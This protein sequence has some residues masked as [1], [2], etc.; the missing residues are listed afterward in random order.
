MRYSLMTALTLLLSPLTLHAQALSCGDRVITAPETCDDGNTRNGDGCSSTCTLDQTIEMVPLVG[1][2]FLRGDLGYRDTIP[3]ALVTI[4]NFSLSRTEITLSMYAKCVDD[5]HCE[6]P[7]GGSFCNWGMAGRSTHPMNCVSW[8]EA[9]VFADWLNSKDTVNTI[10]LPSE[11]QWEYAARSQG[12]DQ[13]YPWG[14]DTASCDRSILKDGGYGCG[15]FSTAPVCS[16]SHTDQVNVPANGDGDSAQGICDLI[17]NTSEWTADWYDSSYNGKPNDGSPYIGLSRN[18]YRVVRGGGW[19]TAPSLANSTVRQRI[20]FRFRQAYTGFRIASRLSCGDGILDEYEEC[21]DGNRID[22][23]GCDASCLLECGN[24]VQQ[25]NE[26]CD[27]GNTDIGDGC[28]ESCIIEICGNG[29]VQINESCDDGALLNG[30]GC[31]NACQEEICGNGILQAAIGEACDDGNTDNNDGCDANCFQEVCGNGVAQ[32]HIGESCD[33]GDND[34]NNGCNNICQLQICG[35]GILQ[36]TEACDDG[37]NNSDLLAGACRT[38]CQLPGCG[39]GVQDTNEACDNGLNNNDVLADACRTNCQLPICGDGVQDSGEA[40]DLGNGN[41]DTAVDGCRTS[42]NFAFCGDGIQDTGEVCDDGINNS[43]VN[44]DACRTSCQ[45]HFCSDGVNDSDEQC[46]D[47]NL[48]PSDGC[49]E[50][51][52]VEECGNGLIQTYERRYLS[53]SGGSAQ[54]C[55][56][57]VDN[58]I[59]CWGESL[60]GVDQTKSKPGGQFSLIEIGTVHACAIGL[61]NEVECWGA[62]DLGQADPPNELMTDVSAGLMDQSCGVKLNGDLVCWGEMVYDFGVFPDPPVGSFSKVAIG[63]NFGV[64]LH[65]CAINNAG[66]IECWGDNDRGQLDA[67]AGTYSDLSAGGD[68]TC[69]LSTT[70]QIDCWGANDFGQTNA[71]AGQFVEVASHL[72]HSCARDINDNVTCWGGFNFGGELDVVAGTYISV[73]VGF[74]HSCA[75]DFNNQ[76]VCWGDTSLGQSTPTPGPYETCDDGN[77]ADGDGCDATCTPEVCGNGVQQ[78]SEECDDNNNVDG[79][80]CSA[81]CQ[82]ESCG[83]GVVQFGEDCDKV[84]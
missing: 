48:L 57:M 1:G 43:D 11:S 17:G 45:P 50:A 83:N 20:N 5:G 62:N 80:G 40:C 64:T 59:N 58:Y 68:F 26:Q 66:Q 54:T 84:V 32:T 81:T 79:D 78:G 23:D 63:G 13:T 7:A 31:D 75:V 61:S 69:A 22:N 74:S 12:Q 27:D 2:V 29:V 71:P 56:I 46:D 19:T 41:S 34:D 72:G 55:G 9:T 18:R 8:T 30:D 10:S 24:G 37:V 42:C 16:R 35:D 3:L 33:D 25:G 65:G 52:L 67:P 73:D 76:V 77:T 15:L 60:V 14:N 49:D 51:C 6:E 4:E 38:T 47:G 36:G 44:P 21:D 39:D 53:I 28:D 82:I 70:G